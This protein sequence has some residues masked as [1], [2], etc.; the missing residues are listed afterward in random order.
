MALFL[1]L[2]FMSVLDGIRKHPSKSHVLP[3]DSPTLKGFKG[4]QVTT[5]TA[6]RS[7]VWKAKEYLRWCWLFYFRDTLQPVGWLLLFLR[8]LLAD[9]WPDATL[10]IFYHL[11]GT[12]WN[13]DS[14]VACL[15][16]CS[17]SFSSM[18]RGPGTLNMMSTISCGWKS[19]CWALCVCVWKHEWRLF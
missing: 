12:V 5:W 15:V 19:I 9:G 17:R 13:W 16:A 4:F 3:I 14:C 6:S 10:N 18:P 7:P 8:D 1:S 2:S 11:Q